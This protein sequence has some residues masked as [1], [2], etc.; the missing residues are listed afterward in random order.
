MGHP[1]APTLA[2]PAGLTL[3][4]VGGCDLTRASLA[5]R[6]AAKRLKFVSNLRKIIRKV[7][8]DIKDRTNQRSAE[9]SSAREA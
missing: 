6:S 2:E 5:Q 1:H 3:L 9:E 8:I 4:P 7:F